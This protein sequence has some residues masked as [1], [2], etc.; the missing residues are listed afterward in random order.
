MPGL[1]R[2]ELAQQTA[3]SR[4]T[5]DDPASEP[6]GT[7]AGEPLPPSTSPWIQAIVACGPDALGPLFDGFL[8]H[9]DRADYIA[10][11]IERTPR[12]G[13]CAP[14]LLRA[15]AESGLK[16]FRSLATYELQHLGADASHVTP[17]LIELTRSTDPLVRLCALRLRE[18]VRRP[19]FA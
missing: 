17:K 19:Y 6:G 7:L 12:E 2:K 5:G 18:C 3:I 15:I 10:E 16:R 9:S 8:Q 14:A 4:Q 11:L 13:A 1:L